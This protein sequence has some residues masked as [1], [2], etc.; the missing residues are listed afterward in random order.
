M[1]LKLVSPINFLRA[2]LQ[3][4]EYSH[5]LSLRRQIYASPTYI[6]IPDS[7]QIDFEDTKYRIFLY[8]DKITCFKC[9]EQ[10]QPASKCPS[11]NNQESSSNDTNHNKEQTSYNRKNTIIYNNQEPDGFL[12]LK[13]H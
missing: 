10:G 9:K 4:T 3:D 13:D 12:D 1:E 5:I 6:P 11:S 8:G 2:G 7:L